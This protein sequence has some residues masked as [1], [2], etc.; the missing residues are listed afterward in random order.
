[1]RSTFDA[2]A[3]AGFKAK[4]RLDP[5]DHYLEKATQMLET[6]D[7]DLKLM[8]WE[9]VTYQGRLSSGPP[10][11]PPTPPASGGRPSSRSPRT[12]SSAVP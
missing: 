1:M 2:R 9:R 12:P 5:S 6:E 4:G 10:P 8:D 3:I 7:W 11:R